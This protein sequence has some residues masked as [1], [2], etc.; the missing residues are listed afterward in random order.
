MQ[1]SKTQDARRKERAEKES[2]KNHANTRAELAV[3]PERKRDAFVGSLLGRWVSGVDDVRHAY[4]WAAC[5]RFMYRCA[6]ARTHACTHAR[7]HACTAVD[8][9]D[10]T[11][12]DAAGPSDS[13]GEHAHAHAGLT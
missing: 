9:K 2:R 10:N 11:P 3:R 1:R 7:T 8:H 13:K 6:A 5:L 12:L 4:V